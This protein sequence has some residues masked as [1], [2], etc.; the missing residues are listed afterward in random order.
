[1][2][3][4]EEVAFGSEKYRALLEL[5]YEI[6]RKPLGLAVSTEDT[7]S[8]EREFHIAAFD[9]DRPVGCVL[10][11]PLGSD[12]I[13]LRQMAVAEVLRNQ[14]LGAKLVRFAEKLAAARGFKTIEMHARRSAQ[15]FYE[16]LG[17]AETG[18]EFIEVTV[19][20]VKM[21]KSLKAG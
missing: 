21:W 17:Y 18:P 3:Q 1:M 20:T 2:I 14:G 13:K 12:T 6:L 16:K 15:V 9:G 5:R 10:L 8:D 7:A 11:R 4:I 19:P